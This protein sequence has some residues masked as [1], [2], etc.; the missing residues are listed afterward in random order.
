MFKKIL[1]LLLVCALSFQG[2][3]FAL[4]TNFSGVKIDGDSD[5]NTGV[6]TNILTVTDTTGSNI[7]TVDG[8]G[9]T[10]FIETGGADTD[11]DFIV[12]GYATFSTVLTVPG[13]AAGDLPT[14]THAGVIVVVTDASGT[15]DCSSGG[16]TI[17]NLCISDNTGSFIDAT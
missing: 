9:D 2:G 16:G 12:A 14:V 5:S 6:T 3:L 11:E 8:A 10:N 1:I 15:T 13:Y 4:D 17:S 7:V